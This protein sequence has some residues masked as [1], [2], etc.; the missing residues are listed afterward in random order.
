MKRLF[1]LVVVVLAIVHGI[2][3]AGASVIGNHNVR[4]A[5]ALDEA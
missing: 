5:A 1:L 3:N 4:I 2:S